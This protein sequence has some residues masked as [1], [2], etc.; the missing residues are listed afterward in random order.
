M[1][2]KHSIDNV[3]FDEATGELFRRVDENLTIIG[4][5]PPQPAE[6]LS[7]MLAKHPEVTTHEEIRKTLWPG[8]HG[9]LEKNIH[10]CIRKIRS[11]FGDSA[12]NPRY[13]ETIPRRGYRFG[14]GVH[15]ETSTTSEG[16]VPRTGELLTRHAVADERENVTLAMLTYK[17]FRP[18]VRLMAAVLFGFGFLVWYF[19]AT[20][21]QAPA[22][23]VAVMTFEAVE[24]GSE[25]SM[26]N[27]IAESVVE[28]L[29]NDGRI[30]VQVIGPTTTVDFDGE[31]RH[32]N[33]LVER[34]DVDFVINGRI[35]SGR[36]PKLLAEIIRAKDGAHVWAQVVPGLT[37]HDNIASSIVCGFVDALSVDASGN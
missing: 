35:M 10:F 32:I 4:R 3:L 8:V 33:D 15:I 19:G 9:D 5:L 22:L 30:D 17:R 23:R 26:R 36:H 12:S 29:T 18:W 2:V 1:P 37:D 31:V 20:R 14:D 16:V 24:A 7:L 34:F 21:T 25:P 13:I 11:A 27:D 6:L 28:L